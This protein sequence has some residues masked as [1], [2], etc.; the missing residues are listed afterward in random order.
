VRTPG[1]PILLVGDASHTAWGWRHG[2]EP[3]TFSSDQPRS[4]DSLRRLRVLVERHP[5]IDVRF[6]HEPIKTIRAR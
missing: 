3:G 1:G 5:A 2:V 4:A 6:G